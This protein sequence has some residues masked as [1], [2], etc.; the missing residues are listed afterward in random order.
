MATTEGIRENKTFLDEEVAELNGLTT[1]LDK[2]N[3]VS[4]TMASKV[5][6]LNSFDTRL[7]SLEISVMP[8]HKSTQSLTRLA[9]NMDQTVSALEAILSY[10]DQAAQ[11]EAIVSRPL[12]DHDL[13]SY[14]QSIGRIREYLRAMSSVKLKAGDRVV[15]QLKRSLNTAS[16]KLHDRFKQLLTQYSLPLD[17]KIV[18]SSDR[19]D[20]PPLPSSVTQTLATL[21]K[22]LADIEIDSNAEKTG[23]LTSYR[24]IR[25]ECMIKSLGPLYQSSMV[26]LKGIYE[27]GSSPF[28]LYTTSLLKLCRNEADLADTLLDA[29]LL[30]LAFMGS[31]MP[32]IEQW[33]ETG[34]SITRRV[35]KTF[36]SEVGILFDVIESLENNM[37]TFDSVFGLAR[38]Q[39]END[40]QELLKAFKATAMRT[41]VDFITDVRNQSNPKYQAMPLDGTVHQLT[42]DTLNYMKRLMNYQSMVESILNLIG[43]GSWNEAGASQSRRSQAAGRS[44]RNA[45]LQHYFADVLEALVQNIETKSRF[46]KKGQSLSQLFLL[47][48]Y[49]YISKSVRTTPGLLEAINGPDTAGLPEASLTSAIYEKPLKQNVNLYQD[50]WKTC[51]EHLMDVTYVQDGGVQQVLNSN[52]RQMVKD[53]FK[54]FNHDFDELWKTQKQYSIPDPDLRVMVL[55]DVNQV[56]IPMYDKFITKYA[57]SGS[58]STEFTKNVQKYIRSHEKLRLILWIEFESSFLFILLPSNSK[59][60]FVMNT[61]QRLVPTTKFCFRRAAFALPTCSAEL[62][63]ASQ[64]RLCFYST[65]KKSPFAKSP[66]VSTAKSTGTVAA[67]ESGSKVKMASGSSANFS[68]TLAELCAKQDVP[69]YLPPPTVHK[70]F[71]LAYLAA[72]LQLVFWGNVAQYAFTHYTDDPIFSSTQPPP[73]PLPLPGTEGIESTDV[74][75][76]PLRK[77]III[78]AGLVGTGLV[79]AFGIC[80]V[81]WRYVTKLTLLKGGTQVRIDT[82]R[83]FPRGYHRV[84]PIQDMQCRQQLVTGVGP[85]GTSPVKKGSSVHIMLGSKKERMAFF[86]DRRGSF[87]DPALWDSVFYRPY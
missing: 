52:Q 37:N 29:K 72:G 65:T 20:I 2:T 78:S 85:Q 56:L 26:E 69:F 17:L 21:A 28:I 53:K 43:D 34:K 50:N 71:T 22:S 83:K 64:S 51:V 19:K 3:T 27:K 30:S 39:K 42:S 6:I 58:G 68:R 11:E 61:I 63:L 16:G 86:V 24:E 38:R 66:K 8:I 84:Y 48:N 82:G 57:S 75:L 87:K 70:T 62:G 59:G 33:V 36:T 12:S 41:F 76:A 74:P 18:T 40:A 79:I 31:I 73:P 4:T 14:L 5:D 81:P 47:N 55:K 45:I 44:G 10:F 46:Y 54:N 77:R 1:N 15:E 32:P 23:Y 49:F 25:A 67:R 13:Q 60:R 9:G 80:A 7:A 35:R